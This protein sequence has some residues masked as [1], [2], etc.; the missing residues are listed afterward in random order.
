MTD[1]EMYPFINFLSSIALS[2]TISNGK[3]QT[4]KLPNIE[5]KAKNY[6]LKTKSQGLNN[7]K[8]KMN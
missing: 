6:K 3:V 7:L 2:K 8:N 1:A 4:A 5:R